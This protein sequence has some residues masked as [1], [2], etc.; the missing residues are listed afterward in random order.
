MIYHGVSVGFPGG[1][2][3]LLW[4]RLKVEGLHAGTLL[5]D[6]YCALLEGVV[7]EEGLLHGGDVA[8]VVQAADVW[9]D[10]NTDMLL[11]SGGALAVCFPH[12]LVDSQVGLSCTDDRQLGRCLLLYIRR[13]TSPIKRVI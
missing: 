13:I 11:L 4:D 7:G 6:R 8:Q 12:A 2:D 1:V 10:L 5:Q 3:L 9:T